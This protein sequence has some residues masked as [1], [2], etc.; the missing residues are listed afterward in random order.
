MT[1]VRGAN[2]FALRIKNLESEISRPADLDFLSITR[3]LP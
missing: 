1:T 2:P 3:R